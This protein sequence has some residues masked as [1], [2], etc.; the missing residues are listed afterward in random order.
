MHILHKCKAFC[1]DTSLTSQKNNN[2]NFHHHMFTSSSETVPSLSSLW[3]EFQNPH[4]EE[5]AWA[6]QMILWEQWTSFCAPHDKFP[7]PPVPL[8]EKFHSDKARGWTLLNGSFCLTLVDFCF[9]LCLGFMRLS[10]GSTVSEWWIMWGGKS[11][12]RVTASL[13]CTNPCCS[14]S[15]LQ[16]V[17]QL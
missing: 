7:P 17:T 5:Q 2:C 8:K 14:F 15:L 4:T 6:K 10:G 1:T 11:K 13:L 16:L 9:S 12:K 3:S